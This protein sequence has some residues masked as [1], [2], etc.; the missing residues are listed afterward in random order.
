[1]SSVTDRKRVLVIDD[2]E[3]VRRWLGEYL[4]DLGYEAYSAVDGEHGIRSA[5]ALR[6]ALILLDLYVPDPSL[7]I[8]FADAYRERVPA[9][10]RAPIIVISGTDRLD[11]LAQRIGADATLAKPFELGEVTKLLVKFLEPAEIPAPQ[12]EPESA[13]PAAELA[14]QPETGSA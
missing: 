10:E 13:A 11:E 5:I 9:E 12:P 14:P 6:P 3:A 8:R 2:D 1:M 4:G 7:A